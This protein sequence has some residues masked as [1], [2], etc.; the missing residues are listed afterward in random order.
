VVVDRRADIPQL[1][2]EHL[3]ALTVGRYIGEILHTSVREFLFKSDSTSV[4][5]VLEN[6]CQMV[7]GCCCSGIRFQNGLQQISRDGGIDPLKDGGIKSDPLFIVSASRSRRWCCCEWND[8][9]QGAMGA[10]MDAEKL[11]PGSVLIFFH[12]KNNRNV[13]PNIG[14]SKNGMEIGFLHLGWG[15]FV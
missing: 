12:L 14:D 8:V 3:E 6:L 5:I 4:L 9:M 13:V 7:P 15:S 1:V 2:R 10:S 11:G